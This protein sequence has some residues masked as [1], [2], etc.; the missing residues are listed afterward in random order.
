MVSVRDVAV[1]T[2][3][4]IAG[5]LAALYVESPPSFARI[6]Q[7]PVFVASAVNVEPEIEQ[8]S[9]PLTTS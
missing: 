4:S 5:E 3:M 6:E 9:K 1:V 7:V 8:Y 2:V